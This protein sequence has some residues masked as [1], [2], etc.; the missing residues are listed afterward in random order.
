M[1][2]RDS[3][4]TVGANWK[5]IYHSFEHPKRHWNIEKKRKLPGTEPRKK[6]QMKSKQKLEK[7]AQF[8]Q[9]S[10]FINATEHQNIQRRNQSEKQFMERHSHIHT[11]K[12][13]RADHTFF[14]VI[15][16]CFWS[17]IYFFQ[18]EFCSK[19]MSRLL[20]LQVF[21]VWDNI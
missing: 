13:V 9:Q 2:I 14:V 18:L 7:A 21:V 20:C 17:R 3:A 8:R 1:C 15:S 4:E 16:K 5:C 10:L 11:I 19:A 6:Q 12:G